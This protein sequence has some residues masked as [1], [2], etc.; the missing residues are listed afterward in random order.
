MDEPCVLSADDPPRHSNVVL[1]ICQICPARVHAL[2]LPPSLSLSSYVISGVEIL[3]TFVCWG[4]ISLIWFHDQEVEGN[5]GLPEAVAFSP[6][7]VAAD[8]TFPPP[9]L[10]SAAGGGGNSV[11]S[12]YHGSMPDTCRSRALCH[13]L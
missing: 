10:A 5:G 4:A 13:M 1:M 11:G 8:D 6:A 7:V 2:L 12:E 9:L 3:P